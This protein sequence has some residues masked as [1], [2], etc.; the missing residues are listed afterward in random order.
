MEFSPKVRNEKLD[1]HTVA[2]EVRSG[3][4]KRALGTRRRTGYDIHLCLCPRGY[5]TPITTSPYH[6][7]FPAIHEVRAQPRRGCPHLSLL[8]P[9]PRNPA[10]QPLAGRAHPRRVAVPGTWKGSPLPVP[11]ALGAEW[12]I[13]VQARVRG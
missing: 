3:N 11:P 1:R 12:D 2:G 10:P 5:P 4:A 7:G 9:E 13:S 8:A 6:A